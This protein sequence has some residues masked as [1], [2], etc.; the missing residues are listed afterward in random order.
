MFSREAQ[1]TILPDKR[2]LHLLPA[3]DSLLPRVKNPIVPAFVI[4]WC[5]WNWDRLLILC[6]SAKTIEQRIT[7]FTGPDIGTQF[8]FYVLAPLASAAVYIFGMPSM[9]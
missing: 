2:Y 4:S 5:L 6:F 3:F 1:T 8:V 9:N 7:K